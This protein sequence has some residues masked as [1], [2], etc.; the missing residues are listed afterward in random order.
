[1]PEWLDA[2]VEERRTV[3]ETSQAE[4]TPNITPLP[5]P[6]DSDIT[7]YANAALMKELNKLRATGEGSRNDQL[8]KAAFALGQLVAGG[9]LPAHEVHDVLTA[10]ARDIGLDPREI[11]TTLRSG[12]T[13]GA[14]HPRSTPPPKTNG[15]VVEV[16]TLQIAGAVELDEERQRTSWWPRPISERAAEAAEA[17]TPTHLRRDDDNALLYAGKV[18]GIIGESESGK[19]WIALLALIQATQQGLRV[20]ILDFEDSP[21]SI[22]RRLIS[23]GMAAEQLALVDYA[24]PIEAL[25]LTQKADLAEAL[26]NT[27]TI[28][29][30]DGVNA[31]MALLGYDLNSN[32]DA[33]L[34]STQ[35]LRPLAR[36]GACV[37]TVDHVPKNPDMR[38]KGGIGAQAK[39]AMIDGCNLTA[40]VLEPFGK[41]HSGVIKLTVDKDRNGSVRGIS[42]NGKNAGKAEIVSIAE[43]VRITIKAPDLRPA[44]ERTWQ[45]TGVMEQISKLLEKVG[46]ALSFRTIKDAVTGREETIKQ[47]LKVLEQ[48]GHVSISSGPNRSLLHSHKAPYR[49]NLPV[50][51]GVSPVSPGDSE[52]GVSSVSHTTPVGGWEHGRHSRV[53]GDG[54]KIS[55]SG[56][57]PD[58]EPLLDMPDGHSSCNRCGEPTP[59]NIIEETAGYCRLCGRIMNP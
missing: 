8:N 17:P 58:I 21:N 49:E 50:S 34:F 9:A 6:P 35:L 30:V 22:N 32:T 15:A 26:N 12:M 51:P 46:G 20:L 38:G 48:G 37:I 2:W 11:T 28:A 5:R 40:E 18:N 42:G 59:E 29:L 33:T 41:G 55:V 1:M 19:S 23:L 36:T 53:T 31:A 10:A 25:G 16:A 56:R 24:D 3:R 45:P 27:Y 47:A 39:R 43:T 52:V 4:P 13:A 57:H 14:K 44:E 7:A 54:H